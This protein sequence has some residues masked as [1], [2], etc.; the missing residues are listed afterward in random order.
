M[1]Q[2]SR[3]EQNVSGMDSVAIPYRLF[4]ESTND[5]VFIVALPD[6]AE[7]GPY[8]EVNKAAC[9]LLGYTREEILAL[10]PR[11]IHAAPVEPEV[12]QA[13][14]RDL[15][16]EGLARFERRLLSADGRQVPVEFNCRVFWMEGARYCLA[17]FR[18]VSERHLSE[19]IL[20]DRQRDLEALINASED[21]ACLVLPDTQILQINVAGAKRFGMTPEEMVGKRILDLSPDDIR[22]GRLEVARR[23]V[24]K[25][26][27]VVFDDFRDG[28]YLH[29]TIFPVSNDEGKVTRFAIFSRDITETQLR[30]SVD[31]MLNA[32]DRQVFAGDADK[33][34]MRDCCTRLQKLFYSPLVC[35]CPQDG[36][37]LLGVGP[38][39]ERLNKVHCEEILATVGSR[40]EREPVVHLRS[41]EVDRKVEGLFAALEPFDVKEAV[42]FRVGTG[43]SGSGLVI[44]TCQYPDLI[45]SALS[46]ELFDHV[47]SRLSLALE[48][49]AEQQQLML[50]RKALESARNALF[51]AN[52]DGHI[53]WT[54]EAFLEMCGFDAAEVI[55]A[56]PAFL[57]SGRQG[58][59]FY[60]NL[61]ETISGAR[62]W[63]GEMVECRKDGSEYTVLQTITPVLAPNGEVSHFIAIQ[64]DISDRKRDEARIR[65]LAEHCPLTGLHNRHYLMTALR[66]FH[67]RVHHGRNSDGVGLLYLDIDLFKQVNDQHGH[68]V[69]DLLLQGFAD[70]LQQ[71]V[72]QDDIVA[73]LGGDEFVVLLRGVCDA[74][75]ANNVAQKILDSLRSPFLCDGNPF[76]I[77]S[78]IGVAIAAP[79]LPWEPEE[80]LRQADDAMYRAKAL[81]RNRYAL[82]RQTGASSN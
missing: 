76:L 78:S 81:G 47:R 18:D 82:Y 31:A 13:M 53:I 55:G 39:G 65:Y 27:T 22:S 62:V 16:E 80:L 8:V 73:R 20:R 36:G 34:L 64:E 70:R 40:S 29:H 79:G 58:E 24:E 19:R 48:M 49:R 30:Q 45:G 52:R 54:N 7:P 5:A 46:R 17:I 68:D 37:G 59:A 56:T 2:R 61:W 10:K 35:F 50:L 43:Q 69:G 15:V 51:I 1:S 3:T 42:A 71:V 44:V 4:F 11:D 57:N 38:A 26:E 74:T 28:M 14:K 25:Q 75:L 63:T 23:V 41:S 6:D 60:R 33:G 12:W 9:D 66:A 21:M 77:T 67:R 72:R 32:M